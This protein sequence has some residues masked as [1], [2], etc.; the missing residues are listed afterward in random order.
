MNKRP[1]YSDLNNMCAIS[2]MNNDLYFRN[3]S[4]TMD[5]YNVE[6]LRRARAIQISSLI[7]LN[8]KK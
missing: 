8:H 3:S 1:K 5:Y 6:S 7:L 2:E 4:A